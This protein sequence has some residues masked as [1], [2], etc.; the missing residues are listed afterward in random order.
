M[1]V[2]LFSL[3][4]NHQM[5]GGYSEVNIDCIKMLLITSEIQIQFMREKHNLLKIFERWLLQYALA[6]ATPNSMHTISSKSIPFKIDV[7]VHL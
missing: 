5:H 7:S 3:Q 1:D 2:R 6:F 4:L